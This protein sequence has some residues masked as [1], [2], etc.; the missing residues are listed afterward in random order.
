MKRFIDRHPFIARWIDRPHR[1]GK[2]LFGRYEI[3]EE[4]GMGATASPTK[5]VI[6][7]PDVLSSLNRRGGQKGKT[8]AVCFNVKRTCY[9]VYV[10]HKFRHDTIRLSK[11][12]S[13][14][15][16]WTISTGRR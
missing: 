8:A 10:I 12:D 14:I 5:D 9:R 13:R 11:A 2:V 15:L 7:T 1:S 6:A 16:S 3:I 4:L